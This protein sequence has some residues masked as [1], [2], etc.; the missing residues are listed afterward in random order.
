MRPVSVL[1]FLPPP[2]V[3]MC[4]EVY[5]RAILT[6]PTSRTVCLFVVYL[7][8]FGW[9]T[10]GHAQQLWAKEQNWHQLAGDSQWSSPGIDGEVSVCL[11]MCLCVESTGRDS[12]RPK[13]ESLLFLLRLPSVT[14][15]AV[16][17]YSS[18]VP[19]PSS[20]PPVFILIITVIIIISPFLIIIIRIASSSLNVIVIAPLSLCHRGLSSNE[21]RLRV[22]LFLEVF[23]VFF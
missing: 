14:L 7:L 4:Y 19:S 17:S 3:L 15:L 9:R 10:R 18:S 22:A 8:D 6:S 2:S 11:C 16:L 23:F 21:G 20:P 5:V 1:L 12:A 13:G